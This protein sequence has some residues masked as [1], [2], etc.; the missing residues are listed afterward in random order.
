MC[1]AHIE[2]DQYILWHMTMSQSLGIEGIRKKIK[3]KTLQYYGSEMLQEF[4]G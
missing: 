2:T 3:V 4:E 1:I